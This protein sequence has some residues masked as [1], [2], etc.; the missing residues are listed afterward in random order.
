MSN[1]EKLDTDYSIQILDS[2]V[3]YVSVYDKSIAF[4]I[5]NIIDNYTTKIIKRSYK[6]IYNNFVEMDSE[7]VTDYGWNIQ[8]TYKLKEYT[9]DYVSWLIEKYINNVSNLE[10]LY[11]QSVE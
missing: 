8:T 1:S 11:L 7:P 10:K 3:L 5:D 2:N 6:S 4:N 9:I